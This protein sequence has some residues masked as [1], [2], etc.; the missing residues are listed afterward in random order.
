MPSRA[1]RRGEGSCKREQTA[2][3]RIDYSPRGPDFCDGLAAIVLTF[4]F[5]GL[6][7]SLFDFCWPLAIAA[8]LHVRFH[9]AVLKVTE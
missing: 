9:I 7:G 8:S 2:F 3:V 5:F 1:H 4:C 6:R